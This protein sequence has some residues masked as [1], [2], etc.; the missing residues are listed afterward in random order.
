MISLKPLIQ[1][2]K[3][4]PVWFDG[5][6]FRCV[7]GAADYA[8]L[9][10]EHLPL[11][12]AWIVR[13]AEKARAAG[14]RA[15]NLSISFDVVIAISNER[16]HEHADADELLLKYRMAVE[17]Q[18]LGWEIEPD[19]RPIQFDG[20]RIIEY[21]RKDIFWA[22]RYSFEALITNYLPDPG[23]FESLTNT[24]GTAL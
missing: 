21:S 9:D 3:P 2:L 8:S 20:G 14:E 16:T 1:H 13:N 23:Q 11:P 15:V 22:D 5:L 4:K 10:P 12:A 24:G 18:L 17:K 6:W 19:V 7:E